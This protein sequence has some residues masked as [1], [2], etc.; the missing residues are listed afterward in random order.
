MK[1]HIEEILSVF[2]FRKLAVHKKFIE[3]DIG[4][5]SNS[6]L[7]LHCCNS[8]AVLTLFLVCWL[9]LLLLFCF[10]LFPLAFLKVPA[11]TGADGCHRKSSSY[12]C[13]KWLDISVPEASTMRSH[14]HHTMYAVTFGLKQQKHRM[15][16][17]LEGILEVLWTSQ[18]A[19]CG[20]CMSSISTPKECLVL[21]SL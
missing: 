4:T 5:L 21:L 3:T 6:A 17:Y 8:S 14:L 9:L 2:F 7:L 19:T 12:Q 20:H 18:K 13:R 1:L 10:V 11:H 16:C 15:I